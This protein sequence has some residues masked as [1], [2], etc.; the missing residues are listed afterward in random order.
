MSISGIVKS[1]LDSVQ[2]NLSSLDDS[3]YNTRRMAEI[4]DYYSEKYRSQTNVMKTIVYFCIPILILG[5]LMKK[6]TCT[7]KHFI[8]C[9]VNFDR[10]SHCYC[11]SS[12]Y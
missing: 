5:I 12:S 2:N 7:K 8:N 6:R 11:G 1:E 10:F 9:Y 3:R 4:N